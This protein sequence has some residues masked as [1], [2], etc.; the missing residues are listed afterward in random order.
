MKQVSKS[1]IMSKFQTLTRVILFSTAPIFQRILL[2]E[3]WR[4]KEEDDKEEQ[5]TN[6]ILN[7][8]L[9]ISSEIVQF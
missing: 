8:G 9:Y 4:R 7:F 1:Q 6:Y 5:E 2:V 3:N